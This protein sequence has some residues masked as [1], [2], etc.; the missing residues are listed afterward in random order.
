MGT[1]SFL[2]CLQP[3]SVT[4]HLSQQAKNSTE[5]LPGNV[6]LITFIYKPN[7]QPETLSFWDNH[8]KLCNVLGR[9]QHGHNS[10]INEQITNSYIKNDHVDF[11]NN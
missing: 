4:S 11:K 5:A 2:I 6:E 9:A 3:L 10:P 8:R 7:L 1:F